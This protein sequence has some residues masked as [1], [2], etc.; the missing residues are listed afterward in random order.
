MADFCKACSI[1]TWGKDFEDMK[2]ISTPEDTEKGLFARVLCEGCGV[3]LVDH[4][5]ERVD[6]KPEN[7]IL[8]FGKHEGK[9]LADVPKDYLNWLAE[10]SYDMKIQEAAQ[11]LI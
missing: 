8:Q 4:T 11:K 6:N 10:N 7:Q 5:G 2:D 9:R 1:E 3:I